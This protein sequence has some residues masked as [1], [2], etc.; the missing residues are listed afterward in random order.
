MRMLFSIK[1]YCKILLVFQ[2]FGLNGAL[3]LLE[4]PLQEK[5][6]IT[7]EMYNLLPFSH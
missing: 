4:F 3:E 7:M 1:Y 2:A 6:M 5:S